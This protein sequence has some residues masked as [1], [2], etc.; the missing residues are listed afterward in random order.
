M[1]DRLAIIERQSGR[2]RWWQRVRSRRPMRFEIC[3]TTCY[4][5][6]RCPERIGEF[7]VLEQF[8][9][10]DRPW[11]RAGVNGKG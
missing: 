9:G 1:N 8:E 2:R 11:Q 7:E 4:V 6:F 10:T 3:G 5:G